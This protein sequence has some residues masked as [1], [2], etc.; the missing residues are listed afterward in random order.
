[1]KKLALLLVVVLIL[2]FGYTK[3]EAARYKI[4]DNKGGVSFYLDG[5]SIMNEKNE[6]VSNTGVVMT[7]SNKFMMSQS[8]PGWLPVIWIMIPYQNDVIFL[9]AMIDNDKGTYRLYTVGNRIWGKL[10]RVQ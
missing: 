7:H 9:R 4:M 2:A 8:Q 3:A 10:V 6:F 1:M 5:S